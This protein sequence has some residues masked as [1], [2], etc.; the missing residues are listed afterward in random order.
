MRFRYRAGF[1]LVELLVVIAIIGI[2]VGLLLPAVQAAREAARRMQCSNNVKQH[3]L[4]ML[5]YESAYKK[6]P[7]GNTGWY[8]TNLGAERQGGTNGGLADGY[9]NGMLS[10]AIAVLPFQEANAIYQQYN[11]GSSGNLVGRCV[12]RAF[13][14]IFRHERNNDK[15]LPRIARI[16]SKLEGEFGRLSTGEQVG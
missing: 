9:Y 13:S 8:P 7:A 4:S 15:T 16:G 14:V 5:N 2:L 12:N 6:F 11:F 1:T 3:A 10:W